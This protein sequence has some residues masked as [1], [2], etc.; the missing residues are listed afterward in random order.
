MAERI[1]GDTEPTVANIPNGCNMNYA[2]CEALRAMKCV[3]LFTMA[4]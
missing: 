4:P 1:E 2:N 3:R